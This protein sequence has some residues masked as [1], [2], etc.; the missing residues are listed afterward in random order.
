MWRRLSGNYLLRN[1][2]I[3]ATLAAA[4]AAT[5][6]VLDAIIVYTFGAD[7]HTDALFAAMTIPALLT[8]VLSIQS[9]KV[10]VPI[11]SDLFDRRAEG[12]RGRSC[13]ASHVRP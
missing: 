2:S 9:P 6:L 3:T 11:F 4:G 8:G 1:A 5:G 13:A 12:K 10:L 7:Y